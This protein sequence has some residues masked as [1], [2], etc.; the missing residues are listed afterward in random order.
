MNSFFAR[1]YLDFQEKITK[2]VPEIRWIEQDMGQDVNQQ[3][4]PNVAFPALLVDFSNTDFSGEA[5]LSM[6]AITTV[7]LKLI[8]APFSQSYHLA[9]QQIKHEALQY[10]EIEHKLIGTLQ[11][12]QKEYFQSLLIQNITSDNHNDT[13]LRIRNITFTTAFELDF[14]SEQQQ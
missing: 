2:H 1:F 5:T 11:G 14:D 10:F 7:S 4:R 13:G 12:W 3:W 8:F 9:P 6:F